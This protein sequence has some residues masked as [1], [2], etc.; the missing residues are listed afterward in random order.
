M[1][2]LEDARRLAP[3][4]HH[5]EVA[6][7][8]ER[9]ARVVGRDGDRDAARGHLVH[10]RAAADPRRAACGGIAVLEVEIAHRQGDDGD[11]RLGDGVEDP[12]RLVVRHRHQR[13]AVAA[14]DGAGKADAF[15]L[16]RDVGEA[17]RTV[18]ERLVDMEVDVEP[19]ALGLGE[20][21]GDARFHRRRE[22]ERGADRAAVFRDEV[23]QRAEIIGEEVDA[24]EAGALKLDPAGPA[25]P[26]LRKH[27]PGD[28]LL[29][30]LAVDV[31][32]DGGG[33][34]GVGGA[35]REFHAGGDVGGGPVARAVIGN[36]LHRVGE[37]A[38]G[39]GLARPDV[40]LV[41]VG[42]H[43]GEGGD[44]DAACRVEVARRAACRLH[45]GDAALRE[46]DVEK[47]EAVTGAAF[48]ER[49]GHGRIGDLH[50]R[51]FIA[52]SCHRRSRRLLTRLR[53]T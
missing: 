25:L 45:P 20:E 27:W 41:E 46:G 47:G 38:G 50:R 9:V 40:A 35:E 8:V 12:V 16:R 43:V 17:V 37:G 24:G 51:S 30:R 13:A 7:G 3:D 44:E 23:E 53:S 15:C 2:E 10:Q 32:A 6:I 36:G 34:V 11:R 28:R 52:L 14:G 49:G 1:V 22:V 39:V 42:V 19:A 31:G 4:F 26:H 29:R 33:A 5:V 48:G 21:G 18:V